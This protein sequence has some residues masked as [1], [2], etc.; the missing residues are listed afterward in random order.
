[1][2]LLPIWEIYIHELRVIKS[3]IAQQ[4]VSS[5]A[6]KTA[7]RRTLRW[8]SSMQSEYKLYGASNHSIL[9]GAQNGGIVPWIKASLTK[10]L[11]MH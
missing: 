1:M 3:K 8:L 7:A 5:E 4:I 11:I 9:L 2:N 6:A 10:Y